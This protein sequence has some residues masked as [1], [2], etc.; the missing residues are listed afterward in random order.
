MKKRIQKKRWKEETTA[1]QVDL[2]ERVA[3]LEELTLRM[4]AEQ[5][6]Q[7]K[8]LDDVTDGLILFREAHSKRHAIEDERR[9]RQARIRMEREQERRRRREDWAK[10]GGLAAFAVAFMCFAVTFPAPEMIE[11]EEPGQSAVVTVEPAQGVVEAVAL[12][13]EG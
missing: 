5:T 1:Q 3:A 7:R 6:S 4:V 10:L 12:S 9:R 2:R 11:P 8:M 13:L